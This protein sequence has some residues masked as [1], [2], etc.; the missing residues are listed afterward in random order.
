MVRNQLCKRRKSRG[1]Y[2]VV[3]LRVYCVSSGTCYINHNKKYLMLRRKIVIFPVIDL[4]MYPMS[5]RM[6]GRTVT[7]GIYLQIYKPDKIRAYLSAFSEASP[8]FSDNGLDS[9]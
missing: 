1:I 9:L 3:V 4:C 5:I 7:K 6:S 8:V 2:F